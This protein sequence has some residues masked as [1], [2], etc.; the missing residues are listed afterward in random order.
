MSELNDFFKLMAE[1]KKTDPKAVQALLVLL[2][3][4]LMYAM[5]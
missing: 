1:G 5:M 3:V 2:E 4:R